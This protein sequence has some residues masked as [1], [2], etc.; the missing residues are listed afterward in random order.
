MRKLPVSHSDEDYE[1]DYDIDLTSNL[2]LASHHS[3][4]STRLATG[5]HSAQ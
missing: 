3:I 5:E 2:N 1:I 4:V